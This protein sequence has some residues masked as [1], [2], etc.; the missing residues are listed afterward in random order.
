ML[1]KLLISLLIAVN[2]MICGTVDAISAEQNQGLRNFQSIGSVFGSSTSYP[3]E[4][5]V[6]IRGGDWLTSGSTM[7][8]AANSMTDAEFAEAGANWDMCQQLYEFRDDGLVSYWEQRYKLLELEYPFQVS[9]SIEALEQIRKELD[10]DVTRFYIDMSGDVAELNSAVG[11]LLK[12]LK[13]RV[14]EVLTIQFPGSFFIGGAIDT[15][16]EVTRCFLDSSESFQQVASCIVYKVAAVWIGKALKK[17][18]HPAT[19]VF[20]GTVED[21]VKMIS[22]AMDFE[23]AQKTI[24]EWRTRIDR[25]I[26][27]LEAELKKTLSYMRDPM[28]VVAEFNQAIHQHCK[29]VPG[30]DYPQPSKD[31]KAAIDTSESK[32]HVD[33]IT[34]PVKSSSN[35]QDESWKIGWYFYHWEVKTL[36]PRSPDFG[37]VV[38]KRSHGHMDITQCQK[39]RGIKR[40][41]MQDGLARTR[42]SGHPNAGL[43]LQQG[44]HTL[45][46]LTD[47]RSGTY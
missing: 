39:S 5:E 30:K 6:F 31:E 1:S 37:N 36:D 27:K 19:K 25:D 40:A 4:Q 35:A 10:E 12:S 46:T 43:M 13:N 28:D 3:S 7:L 45:S 42:V 26:I 47:C 23:A 11:Y 34:S 22:Q 9:E 8:L 41:E 18:V 14:L 20:T 15:V 16:E 44:E 38:K 21:G 17:G 24:N 32:P 2:I 29:G 33:G